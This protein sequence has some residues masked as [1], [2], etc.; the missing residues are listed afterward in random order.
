MKK[1]LKYSLA[2]GLLVAAIL[3]LS[4]CGNWDPP[5]VDLNKDGYNVSVRFDVGDGLFAGIDD[6]FVIDVFNLDNQPT[7]DGRKQLHLL[8]PDDPR[9]GVSALT[10][11]R[12]G[13]FLAGWYTE[14][15][16]RTDASGNPLD[17]YGVPTSE[18]G[19]PQGYTYSGR[20]DFEGDTLPV[21]PSGSYSSE[22][23]VCTLYAAWIPY[24][25]YDVYAPNA[26]GEFEIVAT[27]HSINL[28]VPEWSEKTGKLDMKNFPKR[29]G[30]TLKF[31]SLSSGLLTP[32]GEPI[33]GAEEF[34]DYETGTTSVSSV[35]VYTLWDEG[36]WFRI[37]NADQFYSNARLDGN[38][39]LCADL[40][41]TDAVWPPVLTKGKFTGTIVGNGHTISNVD[42]LQSDNSQLTGGIFGALDSGATVTDLT[43]ENI[44]YTVSAGSRM[45][46]ATFGLF[47]GSIAE[48]VTLDSITLSGKLLISENCYPQDTYLIGLL[49]GSGAADIDISS[50]TCAVAE[51]GSTG[52]SL[53]VD[54]S[55]AVT[56]TFAQ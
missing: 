14:R 3:C 41:F 17:D 22:N 6:V 45:Q 18:S 10:P 31:A 30:Y 52:L 15:A 48:G 56:L 38:Y 53:E 51:E 49:T 2:A 39:I 37:Y 32:M 7:A 12:T 50:I 8:A 26:D 55:G 27:S 34:V 21:D 25:Q 35:P 47:A 23:P 9:R 20:W 16:P 33:H 44:T 13:Y 4:A 1:I 43:F 42:V 36:E 54:D 11:E 28:E 40:D 24:F 19:R 5:Y 29:E 46:G